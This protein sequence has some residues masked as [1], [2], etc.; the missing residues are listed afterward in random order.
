MT[1]RPIYISPFHLF[2]L[3][4]TIILLD[5]LLERAKKGNKKKNF[6]T[7]IIH[8]IIIYVNLLHVSPFVCVYVGWSVSSFYVLQKMNNFCVV[9]PTNN[10]KTSIPLLQLSS[11]FFF[12]FFWHPPSRRTQRST[13]KYRTTKYNGTIRAKSDTTKR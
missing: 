8:T 13:I 7:T 9:T 4:L 10:N 6:I 11:F 5:K 2:Q 3:H 1:Q 12:L